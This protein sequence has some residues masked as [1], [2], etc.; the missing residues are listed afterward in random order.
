MFSV[1]MAKGMPRREAAARCRREGVM[2]CIVAGVDGG[3]PLGGRR[4]EKSHAPP[5]GERCSYTP[6]YPPT[7]V[8]TAMVEC[9]M[10]NGGVSNQHMIPQR[11]L[12]I[13]TDPIS[14]KE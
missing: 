12:V 10:C 2:R 6:T 9:E 7:H 14:Y 4:A 11:E 1:A 13:L 5:S 8:V 3:A